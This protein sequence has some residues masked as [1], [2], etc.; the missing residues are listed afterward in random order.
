MQFGKNDWIIDVDI[1]GM[2]K[3]IIQ[4]KPLNPLKNKKFSP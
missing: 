3:T 1:N 4:L 2:G